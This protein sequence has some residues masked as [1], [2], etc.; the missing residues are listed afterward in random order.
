M[1]LELLTT[2]RVVADFDLPMRVLEL[3]WGN[4]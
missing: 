4:P 1:G 3:W 2:A